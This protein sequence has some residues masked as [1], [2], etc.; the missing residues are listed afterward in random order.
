MTLHTAPESLL[1]RLDAAKIDYELLDHRRTMTAVAEA[2]ALGVEPRR[3]A[4]TVV[5]TT[6]DGF[7]RV[8]LAA[9]DRIDLEKAREV[10]GTDDV[11]LASESVLAGAYP[12][13][14]LGAVPPIVANGDRVLVDIR[15]CGTHSVI[16]EAGTHEQS[17]RIRT[18]D[19]LRLADAEIARI[20]AD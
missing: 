17:L 7:V 14:E 9:S 16:L 20:S 6:P 1:R 4:K 18:A 11:E 15:L 2:H 19:L 13:F 8:V 10:L 12:E 5:L 3:V